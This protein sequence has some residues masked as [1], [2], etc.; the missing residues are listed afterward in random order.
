MKAFSIS[1]IA[2]IGVLIVT[3]GWFAICLSSAKSRIDALALEV[4]CNRQEWIEHNNSLALMNGDAER[5]R[6]RR[7]NKLNDRIHEIETSLQY[8]TP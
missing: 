3:C 6:L 8:V 2:C 7:E 1:C 5:D 4:E